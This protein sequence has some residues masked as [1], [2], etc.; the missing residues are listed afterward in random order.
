MTYKSP[1]RYLIHIEK[2]KYKWGDHM[3]LEVYSGCL[4]I[5]PLR[6]SIEKLS[7]GKIVDDFIVINTIVLNKF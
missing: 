2:F 7:Y 5:E 1:P 6:K 3:D 4:T